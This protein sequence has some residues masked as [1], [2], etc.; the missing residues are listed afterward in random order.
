M[1]IG[2]RGQL[3]ATSVAVIV[4]ALV[5]S[6]LYLRAELKRRL[7]RSIRTELRTGAKVSREALKKSPG[8]DITV[9]DAVADRL[10]QATETRVTIIAK[11]GRVLGDSKLTIPQVRA[12]ENHGR[13]PEVLEAYAKGIGSSHRYS[14]TL[15]RKMLYLAVPRPGGGVVRLARPTTEIDAALSRLNVML[16]IGSLIGVFI[17]IVMSLLASHLLS[18]QLRDL[19]VTAREMVR[20]NDDAPS[21]SRAPTNEIGSLAGTLNQ[22]SDELQRAMSKLS[23]ERARLEAVLRSMGEA[24]I[25]LNQRSRIEFVNP[26]A[27][28][29]LGLGEAP[30]GKT[31]LETLRDSA[32]QEIT[33]AALGGSAAVTEFVLPD[34]RTRVQAT[35]TPQHGADGC[36]LVFHDVTEVRRLERVRRDFVSNVSHELRTPVSV[37][38]ANAETL[39]QAHGE[40]PEL[41]RPF[42][43]AILR[44]ADRLAR[45]ISDLLDLARLE[46]GRRQVELAPVN[47]AAAVAHAAETVNE[48]AENKHIRLVHN[49]A[50]TVHV[51]ADQGSLDQILVNLMDNAVKYSPADSSVTVTARADN[52][53]VR[54]E[55]ADEGPGIP[56]EHHERVFERFYRVDAGR[57]RDLGGTGLG[58]AIVKDLVEGMRGSV[59]LAA[60]EPV[61]S[62]FWLQLPRSEDESG[63]ADSDHGASSIAFRSSSS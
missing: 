38:R 41:T 61:G 35:A 46:A 53:T 28:H 32:L 45:I 58:L 63:A 2:V 8:D 4:V 18:R 27:L 29:L 19:V 20:V 50:T 3:F 9:L 13:R 24:V 36:I 10:G 40:D 34:Q 11:D 15:K 49:I 54:V 30:I 37:M 14:T 23:E 43:E 21:A 16:L 25:S 42:L 7:F 5:A 6:G 39:L 31:M 22:M 55:V 33:A 12:V 59:G 26:Q 60:N 56:E 51:R 62:V 44:H 52:G 48:A 17:A 47:V 1:K 57:S